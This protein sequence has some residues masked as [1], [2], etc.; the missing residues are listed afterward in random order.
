LA[1]KRGM[2]PLPK[3]HLSLRAKQSR[4]ALRMPADI[5]SSLRSSQ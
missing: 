1:E 4:A 2:V 5:A 3:N